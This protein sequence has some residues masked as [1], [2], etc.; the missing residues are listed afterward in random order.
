MVARRF[1][2]PLCGPHIERQRCD[3]W[4]KTDRKQTKVGIRGAKKG[5]S[6]T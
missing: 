3:G 1:V 6:R 5:H 4:E 2:P